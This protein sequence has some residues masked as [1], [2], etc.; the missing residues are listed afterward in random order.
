MK[1]TRR[2][3]V[4][5]AVVTVLGG[6]GLESLREWISG[7]PQ[8]GEL[9]G[10]QPL[11]QHVLQD[12]Q[13]VLDEGVEVLVPPHHHRV[14]TARVKVDPTPP[15]LRD[16][17]HALELALAD[18]D[19]RY[20][21]SSAG[22]TVT[23]AW[24]IP[25]FQRFVP[26]QARREI[27]IDRRASAARSR[28]IRVLV[29]AERFPSDPENT[30]LEHNDIAVLLR[31][32]NLDAL[33]EAKQRLFDDLPEIFAVTSIRNGFIGGGFEGKRSLPNRMLVAARIP[34]GELM[35]STAELFLG[36]TS[37]VKRGLGPPK[38]ANFETLGYAELPSGYFVGGTHMHLS[39]IGENLLAWYLNFDH[40]ARVE[41]MFR[42]GLEVPSTRQTVHQAPGDVDPIAELHDD[43]ARRR[44][45][46]HVS[47]IQSASRLDRDVV[48]RD[49]T[50]YKKGTA[51]PQRA[52]FNTLDNPFAWSADPARDRMK[53]EP[54]AGVHF[55]VF[56]P[57]SDDFARVRR[58]MDGVLP[59]G[60]RLQ[61]APR[62]IGQGL[63]SV[64]RTTHRQNFLVP[65]R[66]HRSFPLAE[67]TA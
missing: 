56:N 20:P 58:A 52:D 3:F 11:E 33:D 55:V 38:I 42:P 62:S 48:S 40:G 17:R 51:V 22:L 50:I 63:N 59:D 66:A 60:S 67:L 13:I 41:A 64:L 15:A 65:P 37:T 57:T 28:E 32:D 23:A 7:M 2:H 27:P 46:G 18:L 53:R 29:D 4:A 14:V 34:G 10:R 1:F 31:S 8:R 43:Y 39:H 16:A 49:G 35:P 44:R 61:F 12:A 24:G 36:F 30:V 5:G 54:A 45:V 19:A 25:Y 9:G 6:A 47:A 26:A 21:A